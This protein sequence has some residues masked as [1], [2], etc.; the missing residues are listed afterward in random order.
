MHSANNYFNVR[1]IIPF[2]VIYQFPV[3]LILLVTCA[4]GLHHFGFGVGNNE[5]LFHIN[6][7]FVHKTNPLNCVCLLSCYSNS[8]FAPNI[9]IVNNNVTS[10]LSG[11][12]L[13]CVAWH[14]GGCSG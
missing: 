10:S 1:M 5:Y 2:P 7:Y 14:T 9:R 6:I 13:A 4:V 12:G 11:I 8:I 3:F